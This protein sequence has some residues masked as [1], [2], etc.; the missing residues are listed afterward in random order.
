LRLTRLDP[1]AQYRVTLVNRNSVST[2]SRGAPA[3]KEGPMT[4]SGQYLMSQGL[5]L[6]WS[7][8]ETMWVV[9]GKRL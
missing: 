1:D 9:E 4:L 6:P 7:F 5:T 2:L 8:P 3:L